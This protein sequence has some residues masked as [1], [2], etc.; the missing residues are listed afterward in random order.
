[1]KFRSQDRRSHPRRSNPSSRSRLMVRGPP[2]QTRLGNSWTA[3]RGPF[4]LATQ[5]QHLFHLDSLQS[6]DP[7]F[8]RRRSATCNQRQSTKQRSC[9]RNTL[10]IGTPR[11]GERQKI[12]PM[13]PRGSSTRS[14]D[15]STVPMPFSS[16]VRRQR[17]SNFSGTRKNT[18]RSSKQELLVLRLWIIR[19][20]EKSLPTRRGTS[21]GA[22]GCDPR[23]VDIRGLD[24]R[25]LHQV[26]NA[27]TVPRSE[28]WRM[29]K[30]QEG[31]PQPTH[32]EV[33]PATRRFYTLFFGG[34]LVP[35]TAAW[36]QS[37]TSNARMAI[38]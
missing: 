4:G 7:T 22:I 38:S 14:R 17:S 13:T 23:E 36:R 16:L 30:G 37:L 6:L 35:S 12:T 11:G 20:T 3:A 8:N 1:L 18:T 31:C 33:L 19:P 29:P 26:A 24:T 21:G 15:H 32:P 27:G 5:H 28:T 10:S 34:L 2:A 9:L 25:S